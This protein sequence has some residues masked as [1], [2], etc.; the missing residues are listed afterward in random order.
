MTYDFKCLECSNRFVKEIPIEKYG[1]KK[2]RCPKC[3]SLSVRRV[4]TSPVEIRFKGTGFYS[5]DNKKGN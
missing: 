1:K 3:Q 4:I 5:T 2:I